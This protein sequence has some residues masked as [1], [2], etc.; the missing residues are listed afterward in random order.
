MQNLRKIGENRGL[1]GS[2]IKENRCL[3]VSWRVLARLGASWGVVAR[4]WM[5]FLETLG[6]DGRNMGQVGGKLA[7][8]CG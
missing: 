5:T 6:E 3:E 2:K 8:S 1:E 7:A 4:F